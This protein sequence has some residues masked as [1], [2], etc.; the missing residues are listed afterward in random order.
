[1]NTKSE[2]KKKYIE[3]ERE[4]NRLYKV[5]VRI[6]STDAEHEFELINNLLCMR[7]L[8]RSLSDEEQESDKVIAKEGMRLAL[9]W[10]TSEELAETSRSLISG[11]GLQ[12]V[13]N[14]TWISLKP[15]SQSLLKR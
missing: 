4:F 12:G 6:E 2:V 14:N 8:R 15:R 1:M 7:R 10:L 3:H 11:T 5:R 13:A 9:R